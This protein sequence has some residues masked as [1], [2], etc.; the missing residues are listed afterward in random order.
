[1]PAHGTQQ[2]CK[3]C[4]DAG[5]RCIALD[6]DWTDDVPKCSFCEDGLACP[7]KK[8]Q[9]MEHTRI[10]TSSVPVLRNDALLTPDA[11]IKK[12]ALPVVTVHAAKPKEFLTNGGEE[13]IHAAMKEIAVRTCD[14]KTVKCRHPEC[15]ELITE[16]N[17]SGYCAKH[18]YWSTKNPISGVPPTK[19]SASLC[20]CGKPMQHRGRCKGTQVPKTKLQRKAAKPAA[21]DSSNGSGERTLGS[22]LISEHQLNYMFLSWSMED[23]LDCVQGWLDRTGV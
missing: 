4:L 13:L 19:N 2:F 11:L 3:P 23:K 15:P 1:M 5:H 16:R 7:F 12:R 20:K 8:R 18:F 9:A 17:K 22:L 14:A 10:P 6:L 21:V